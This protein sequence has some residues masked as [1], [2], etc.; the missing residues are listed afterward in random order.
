M[1]E[2][3]RS[4]INDGIGLIQLATLLVVGFVVL[5]T[6]MASRSI[7]K[8]IG[9]MLIGALVLGYIFNADWFGAKAAEDIRGRE[10]GMGIV[11]EV[12]P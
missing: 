6:F 1:T 2:I 3:I 7:T 12:H 9:M 4:Y 5:A 11:V 8:T 10:N